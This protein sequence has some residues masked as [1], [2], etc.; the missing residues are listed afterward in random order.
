MALWQ[1]RWFPRRH[2]Y[3][4]VF[5]LTSFELG[6]GKDTLDVSSAS[7]AQV[8]ALT[9]TPGANTLT[10]DEIIVNDCRGDHDLGLDL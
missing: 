6:T 1:C 4:G 2:W 10:T 8:A 7:A 3:R 9:T 5:S